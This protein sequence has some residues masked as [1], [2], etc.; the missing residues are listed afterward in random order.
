MYR[1]FSELGCVVF[2][3]HEWTDRETDIQTRLITILHKVISM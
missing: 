3:I 1:K 2:E